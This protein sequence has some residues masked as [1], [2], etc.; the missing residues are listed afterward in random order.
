MGKAEA[1]GARQRLCVPALDFAGLVGQKRVAGWA[2]VVAAQP[3]HLPPTE[4]ALCC[5]P[6]PGQNNPDACSLSP[7]PSVVGTWPE[8][9][10]PEVPTGALCLERVFTKKQGEFSI[11]ALLAVGAAS[12][13]QDLGGGILTGCPHGTPG[14]LPGLGLDPVSF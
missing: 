6:S 7:W 4:R 3:L 12:S 13:A 2:A 11:P 1:V 9:G 14:P 10:Q 8:P 5:L